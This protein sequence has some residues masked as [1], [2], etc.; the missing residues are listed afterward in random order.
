MFT[1]SGFPMRFADLDGSIIDVYQATTQ[2]TDESGMDYP[3]HIDALLDG[4]LGP[5]GYYGV[6][7]VNMHTDFS[8]HPGADAVVAAAQA[9]GVPIVSSAQMLD[10]LDG[11]NGASFQDARLRRERVRFG[12]C[13]PRARGGSRRWCR[14]RSAGGPL[15]GLTADGVPVATTPRTVKGVEYAVFPAAAAAYVA[16]Y[17]AAAAPPP[18]VRGQGVLATDDG[19][20]DPPGDRAPPGRLPA[21]V[22]AVPDHGPPAARRQ[23]DRA[24]EGAGARPGG[25]RR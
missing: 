25:A 19:P 23:D 9:R 24:R 22:P 4:A 6:F 10:W 20:G 3:V 1:G 7:T 5:N 21:H 16:A 12:S 11:R 15:L 8:P 17:P 2:M 18:S 14:P 13:P